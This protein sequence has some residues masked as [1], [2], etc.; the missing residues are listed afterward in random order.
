M[1]LYAGWRRKGNWSVQPR[2][3]VAVFHL[4]NS[5]VRASSLLRPPVPT[6]LERGSS[7]PHKARRRRR[8]RRLEGGGGSSTSRCL[9]AAR[10]SLA[11]ARSSPPDGSSLA[12]AIGPLGFF[13]RRKGERWGYNGLRD[14]S[15]GP[16]PLWS[17]RCPSIAGWILSGFFQN[18]VDI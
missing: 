4:D 17:K 15:G 18:T 16:S 2:D 12:R 7:E 5:F 8:R 3:A 14:F 6:V 9:A 1:M 10:A 13:I 11:S